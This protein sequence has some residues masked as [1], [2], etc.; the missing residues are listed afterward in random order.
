[1]VHCMILSYQGAYEVSGDAYWVELSY[2]PPQLHI[3]FIS[4]VL[5]L[6]KMLL[7]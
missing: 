7:S 1:M 2:R 5:A 4:V 6:Q 3:N